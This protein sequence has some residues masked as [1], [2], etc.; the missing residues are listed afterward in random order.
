MALVFKFADS[1]API[2]ITFQ[3]LG[4]RLNG[5]K[6]LLDLDFAETN[7]FQLGENVL[8]SYILA[9]DYNEMKLIYGTKATFL[10]PTINS[11]IAFLWWSNGLILGVSVIVIWLL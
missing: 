8:K 3:D 6:Y 7:D 4:H 2:T 5:N 11:V 9:I 10:W 1:Q